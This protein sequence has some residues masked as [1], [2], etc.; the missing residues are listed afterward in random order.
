MGKAV[1]EGIGA[2]RPRKPTAMHRL[3]GNPGKR[4]LP[5]EGEEPAPANAKKGAPPPYWLDNYAKTAWKHLQPMLVDMRVYTEADRYALELLVQAYAEYRRACDAI[6]IQGPTIWV[7]TKAGGY[8]MPD[9][10]IRERNDAWRRCMGALSHFGL[11]PASRA[12]IQVL[13]KEEEGDPFAEFDKPKG[14]G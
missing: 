11:T 10:A 2:G 14:V 4:A 1:A 8:M 3:N 13:P 12:R 9:P 7:E 5:K 6:R